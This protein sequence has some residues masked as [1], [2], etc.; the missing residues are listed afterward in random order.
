[1]SSYVSN[2]RANKRGQQKKK[3]KRRKLIAADLPASAPLKATPKHNQVAA[4]QTAPH[5]QSKRQVGTSKVVTSKRFAFLFSVTF[6]VV[7]AAIG[8][9]YI[10]QE[11]IIDDDVIVAEVM[12]APPK[13]KLKRLSRPRVARTQ[14]PR[15]TVT[16]PK[17]QLNQVVTTSARFTTP[18]SLSIAPL[19]APGDA[20]FGRR[21]LFVGERQ[22]Q[23]VAVVPQFEA[24]K[25]LNTSIIGKIDKETNIAQMDFNPEAI[26]LITADLRNATQS[27][28]EF[29]KA[30]RDKIKRSQRYPQSVRELVDDSTVQVQFTIR[31]DG[32]L[33]DA[34][35]VTSSGSRALDAAALSAI[36]DATPFPPFPG[37]Q[38]GE[39]LRLEIPIVFQLK[40]N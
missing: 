25:F 13:P 39:T 24:P 22:A 26:E 3:A 14:T 5:Q 12:K 38:A 32:T 34:K 21:G 8:T 17:P 30:I 27:L 37:D 29:L 19:G 1:M 16:A 36:R 23:V 20:G 6:H 35:V 9:L 2:Y 18:L 4:I 7:A 28:S 11:T 40:T 31:H 33:V 15:K 10:V